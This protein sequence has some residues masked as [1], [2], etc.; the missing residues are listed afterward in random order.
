MCVKVTKVGQGHRKFMLVQLLHQIHQT[1]K[2][3]SLFTQSIAT[4]QENEQTSSDAWCTRSA[5]ET[6]NINIS[7]SVSKCVHHIFP[8]IGRTRKKESRR[9]DYIQLEDAILRQLYN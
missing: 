1:A 9:L 4:K 7:K 6:Q 8:A 3:A 2:Y 5:N